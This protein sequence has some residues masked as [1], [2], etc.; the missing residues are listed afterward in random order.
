MDGFPEE[1][2]E[3]ESSSRS[4]KAEFPKTLNSEDQRPEYN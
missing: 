3:K 4:E 1:I 2:L